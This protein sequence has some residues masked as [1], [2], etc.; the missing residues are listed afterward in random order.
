MISNTKKK[1]YDFG[2]GWDYS[3]L[4]HYAKNKGGPERLVEELIQ[5]GKDQMLPWAAFTGIVCFG[6][7]V[8]FQKLIAYSKKKKAVK[9]FTSEAVKMG[10]IN[11]IEEYDIT[12]SGTVINEKTEN[13]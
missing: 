7:G 9:D 8:L 11:G 3:A 2:S 12:H 4:S 5:T 10:L 13:E 6:S 1:N